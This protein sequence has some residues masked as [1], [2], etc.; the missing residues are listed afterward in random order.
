MNAEVKGSEVDSW[1]IGD[2][3]AVNVWIELM[4]NRK[5][6]TIPIR[7]SEMLFKVGRNFRF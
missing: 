7:V 1:G 2:W 3:G 5:P 6:E 4:H